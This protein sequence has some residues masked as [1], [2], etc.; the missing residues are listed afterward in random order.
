M[1]S[2][3]T[4]KGIHGYKI[5]QMPI[6]FFFFKLLLSIILRLGFLY[7]EKQEIGGSVTYVQ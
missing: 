4:S 2:I 5:R 3:I 6:L 1:P 7:P